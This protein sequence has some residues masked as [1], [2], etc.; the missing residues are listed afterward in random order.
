MATAAKKSDDDP[1]SQ[2]KLARTVY[3]DG[4]GYGPDDDVPAE[5]AAQITNPNAWATPDSE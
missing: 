1:K 4:K 2:K 3:V 5:V